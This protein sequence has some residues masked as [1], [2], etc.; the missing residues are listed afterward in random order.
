MKI[1]FVCSGN[2]CRSPMAQAMMEQLLKGTNDRGITVKS[3][4]MFTSDGLPASEAAQSVMNEIGLDLSGHISKKINKALIADADLIFTMTREQRR[5]L[6]ESYPQKVSQIYTI[7]EFSGEPE[8]DIADPYGM[9]MEAYR[10]T[11]LE[12]KEMLMKIMNLF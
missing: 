1:L 7:G 6:A 11:R 8:R 2:T 5:L 10:K 9:G 3:A 4:G 12:L